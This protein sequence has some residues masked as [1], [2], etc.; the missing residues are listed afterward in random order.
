[1]YKRSKRTILSIFLIFFMLF[2]NHVNVVLSYNLEDKDDNL[3]DE[4]LFNMKVHIYM[5]IISMPSLTVCVIK[6]DSIIW[7]NSYGF[8]NLYQREKAKL[9]TIYVIGSI[10]KTVRWDTFLLSRKDILF[11]P[12][13]PQHSQ[14]SKGPEILLTIAL[15]N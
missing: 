8:S 5:K 15:V 7:S 10:S 6:N 12:I 1:M 2:F 14:T 9:D 11:P 3:I 4:L 13:P